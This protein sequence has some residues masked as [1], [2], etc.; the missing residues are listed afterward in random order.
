[1]IRFSLAT[2][3]TYSGISKFE[4]IVGCSHKK[5]QCFVDYEV[6]LVGPR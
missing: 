3:Y 6:A 5:R 2:A 1:M 4:A